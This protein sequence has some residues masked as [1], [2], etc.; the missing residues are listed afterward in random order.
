MEVLV[1]HTPIH[2]DKYLLG[3]RVQSEDLGTNKHQQQEERGTLQ[4]SFCGWERTQLWHWGPCT[5]C[6]SL[7]TFKGETPLRLTALPSSHRCR[8]KA[9][10]AGLLVTSESQGPPSTI[11]ASPW[12]TVQTGQRSVSTRPGTVG[13]LQAPVFMVSVVTDLGPTMALH[14]PTAPLGPHN[15]HLTFCLQGFPQPPG[16]ALF[17]RTPC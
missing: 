4:G 2:P 3:L 7:P 13:A 6:L 10:G 11:A 14:I 17:K 15:S 9:P 12:D 16:L 8:R 1:T 5:L